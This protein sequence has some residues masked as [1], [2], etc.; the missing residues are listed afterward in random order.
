MK[1]KI[2]IVLLAL[3]AALFVMPFSASASTQPE[4]IAGGGAKMT[5]T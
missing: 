3:C 4:G 5:L 1:R 2:S